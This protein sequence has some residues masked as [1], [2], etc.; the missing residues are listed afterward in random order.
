MTNSINLEK[1]VKL[2]KKRDLF[3]DYFIYHIYFS[4]PFFSFCSLFFSLFPCNNKYLKSLMVLKIIKK[5]FITKE[6]QD[7]YFLK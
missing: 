4:F 2:T 1:D 6:N 7:R 5:L 3:V